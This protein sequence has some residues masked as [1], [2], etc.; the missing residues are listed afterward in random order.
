MADDVTWTARI[1]GAWRWFRAFMLTESGGGLL[2]ILAAIAAVIVAN[3]AFAP[4][5]DRL[6]EVRVAIR[7]GPAGLSKS[8]IHWVND[9]LMALFFLLVGLE[10]KREVRI[11]ALSEPR[12]LVLPGVAAV[13][14]MVVPAAI[15]AAIN[16]DNPGALRGWAVPAATDIAFALGVLAVLG[17]RVPLALKVLLTTIAVIDDIGAILII[18]LF[19]TGDIEPNW[20]ATA[21]GAFALMLILNRTGM[22]KNWPFLILG[23]ILWFCVLRSGIHATLA[24]V[25]TALVVPLGDHA[26]RAQSPLR[27]LE[28]HLR[29]RVS[30]VILPLFAFCNAGVTLAPLSLSSLTEPIPLGII[31]GL[32]L[33]KPIGILGG[34]AAATALGIARLPERTHWGG[35]AAVSILAGIGFTMS[36]FI[37]GLGFDANEAINAVRLGVLSASL[38][39]AVIGLTALVIAFPAPKEEA[40]AG[41]EGP[42]EAG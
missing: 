39:A 30:L 1:T 9:G 32:V 35:L 12:E 6:L 10:I 24:G 26:D 15:Y 3:S 2:L 4:I 14:G 19:Y 28:E 20:L 34:A 40:P 31:A 36:L 13:C 21:G 11:G 41:A 37:G 18:A 38:I 23:V 7:I 42:P 29:P 27:R 22:N 16:H 8:L 25:V 33:G 17:S 5:Y